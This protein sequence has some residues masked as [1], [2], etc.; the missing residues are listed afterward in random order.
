MFKKKFKVYTF[1]KYAKYQTS[2]KKATYFILMSILMLLNLE[3]KFKK[4]PLLHLRYTFF[5]F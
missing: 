3:K 2:K 4:F 1:T 5:F